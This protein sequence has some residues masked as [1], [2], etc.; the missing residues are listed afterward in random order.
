MG[1]DDEGLARNRVQFLTSEAIEPQQ[2][3][4][5]ILASWWRSR[6][7][8]VPAD[9]IDLPYFGDQN[10]DTPLIRGAG[11]VLERLG[12]QLDG[13]PISMILTDPDGVVLTQRTGDADL[14]RHLESVELAPGFSYG[15]QFV[16]TNGI[17]TALQDGQPTHVFGHEHYAEH[18]EDLACAGVPIR[19]PISGKMIGALDLTCWRK[20]AGGLLVALARTTAEQVRQALLTHS[21]VRELVL[22]QAYLQA[23][24]RTTGIV[25]AFND[26]L[27]MMNDSARGLLG[28]TDQALLLAHA[29]HALADNQRT[30]SIVALSTG[31]K[32]RA[33]CR[34]VAGHR[35]GEVAGGVLSVQLL[36]S[37]EDA[38][39]GPRPMLP[40][41]LP[42]VVGSASTWSRCSYEVDSSYGRRDWLVLAGE[43]GVGK[44][45][46]AKGV[47]E[48]RNAAG[49]LHTLDAKDLGASGWLADVRRDMV[50][51][52]VDAFV[53]RHI[54][55][56]NSAAARGVAGQ[57]R[58]A[59]ARHGSDAPW[60]AATQ[61]Q[62]ARGCSALEELLAFFPRTVEVPPL[63]RHIEDLNELVPLIL[64]NLSH[65]SD[66]TCSPA[67]MHLLMRST[68]QGNVTALRQVLKQIVRRRRTG[69]ILPADLP[70]EFHATSRRP[71]N[72]VET[73]ERDIIV[74]SLED[75]DGNKAKAAQ[76]LGISRATI[77][78]KIHEYGIITP[79]H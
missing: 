1:A 12:D 40:M 61:T 47:H 49:R 8:Q 42:G 28:P 20:D 39:S 64:G 32:V 4:E 23:C 36:E 21:N 76:L 65:G 14:H 26:D 56:F 66:L 72:R 46:L 79:V 25:I 63:R 35:S 22:F 60:V 41:F 16:G 3:R 75:A 33:Q 68:W 10:L 18:L 29:T 13:Q 54:D 67:T 74:R 44:Y 57:L 6:E 37:D 11:P 71:L 5:A 50:E 51:D 43:P 15:E 30:T 17:G 48:R 24:R 9:R 78:R 27:V 53:I 55:A 31:G 38:E 73:V 62:G 34:R 58:E 45:A 2:V 52:P 77:Y 19:H 7:F 59:R 70:A 69:S